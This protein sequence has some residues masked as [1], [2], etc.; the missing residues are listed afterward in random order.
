MSDA[1]DLAYIEVIAHQTPSDGRHWVCV[2]ID[3]K[4]EQVGPFATAAKA[5]GWAERYADSLAPHMRKEEDA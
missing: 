1:D 4:E 3:D 5:R 2:R